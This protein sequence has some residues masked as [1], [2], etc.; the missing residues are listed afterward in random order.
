MRREAQAG[1]DQ[2]EE[3]R[4]R[5]LVGH[6][7][8]LL[9]DVPNGEDVSSTKESIVGKSVCSARSRGR[10]AVDTGGLAGL[11]SAK[12]S[13]SALSFW[14]VGSILSVGSVLSIGSAGSV[15]SIGSAGS[16]LSIGSA[17]SILSIGGAG[18][19]PRTDSGE[20]GPE[21]KH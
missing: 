1:T 3:I 12:S 5:E 21:G 10:S 20:P 11:L 2:G 18:S 14:S 19:S 8:R 15:L 9:A 6:A 4:N 7:V 13:F 17:G 16:I